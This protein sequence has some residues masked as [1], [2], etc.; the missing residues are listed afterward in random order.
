MREKYSKIS[1]KLS[2]MSENQH[3]PLSIW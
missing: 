2:K 3:L 1:K